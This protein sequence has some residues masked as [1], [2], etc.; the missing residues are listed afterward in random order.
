MRFNYKVSFL[1]L[2]KHAEG[3][4][5]FTFQGEQKEI[6]I[7]HNNISINFSNYADSHPFIIRED[8]AL[9]III[10]YLVLSTNLIIVI[11]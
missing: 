9:K 5:F 10:I 2:I 6:I 7:F 3:W 4:L 8:A 1:C 11:W